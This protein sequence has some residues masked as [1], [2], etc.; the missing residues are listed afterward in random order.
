MKLP[1]K[2]QVLALLRTGTADE[3]VAFLKSLP[4]N[5]FTGIALGRMDS[6]MP[7]MIVAALEQVIMQY[8]YGGNPEIG[9]VL[10][11]AAHERAVEIWQ[12]V[13]NHGLLPTT[14]SGLANDH[15]KALSLLGRSEEVL[16]ATEGYI[17]FYEK[18]GEHENLPSL[19]VLRIEALVNLKR[20][21]DAD[22]SAALEPRWDRRKFYTTELGLEGKEAHSSGDPPEDDDLGLGPEVNRAAALTVPAQPCESRWLNADIHD[23]D[24]NEPLHLG[25]SY[26]LE[27]GVD[28]KALGDSF[29]RIPDASLLF[30]PGEELIELIVQLESN[31]FDVAQNTQVLKLPRTGASLGKA[32]FKI[33]PKYAG[34]GTLTAIVHKEGNFVMQMEITYSIGTIAAEPPSTVACGRSIA[35][36]ANLQ[37]RNLSMVIKPSSP[38]DG[39]ECTLIGEGSRRVILPITQTELGDAVKT[40]REGL[41]SV[42]SQR[43]GASRLVFQSGLEIDADSAKKALRTLARSGARLFQRIFFGPQA[44]IEV[45]QVGEWLRTRAMNSIGSL[46]LQI[47]AER[48]PIPWGLLY[49]GDV[50]AK[51]TLSWD[52]FLGMRYVIEIIPMVNN[53]NDVSVLQSDQPSLAVSVNVNAGIDKQMETDVVARQLKFWQ[54]RASMLGPRLQLA[55]RQ[56]GGDLLDALAGNAHDQLMYFYCHAVSSGP[57]DPGGSDSAYLVLTDEGR[58][59]LGDLNR[60]APM[61]QLLCGHP[62]VFINAC[63]SAELTPSFYDGFVPYFMGKGAHGVIGTECKIPARFAA[64][65]ALRFFP[66]F[67]G[68][69]P[70]GELFLDLRREFCTK[71]NNPLGLLYAVYCN[72]DT[73]IQPELNI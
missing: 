6:D 42:V 60:E 30:G 33:V 55:Q 48:F 64:E 5:E 41:M 15:V 3:R 69:E 24:K 62:L 23:H 72:G 70:L 58:V 32:C 25:E 22:Y 7:G 38:A 63:E 2:E 56:S 29:A 71:Q 12:T 52:H 43:D 67:L 50:G 66:R 54:D 59:T 40:A 9:A 10:A 65:W 51:G 27:F 18:L 46:K 39:Y 26:L 20:F 36:A 14:L 16:K 37:P 61:D 21:D 31:H 53:L 57:E 19:K 35:A 13:P 11:A 8:C 28:T 68:G 44:G 45:K 34:R 47:V 4:P 73:R 17:P 49:L 1:T